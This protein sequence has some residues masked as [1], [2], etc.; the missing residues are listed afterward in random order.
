MTC[1]TIKDIGYVCKGLE[2]PIENGLL[3]LDASTLIQQ[4]YIE[5][6]QEPWATDKDCVDFYYYVRESKE[7]HLPI[8][9]LQRFKKERGK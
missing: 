6:I 4:G 1:K 8:N 7:G 3:K 2:V 9:I 5:E